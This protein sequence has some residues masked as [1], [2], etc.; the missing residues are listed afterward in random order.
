MSQIVIERA[1]RVSVYH[2]LLSGYEFIN[3]RNNQQCRASASLQMSSARQTNNTIAP[4]NGQR[5][6]LRVYRREQSE[7][8]KDHW[9]ERLPVKCTLYGNVDCVSDNSASAVA[10][11][12]T[13]WTRRQNRLFHSLIEHFLVVIFNKLIV[14]C[15]IMISPSRCS[16]GQSHAAFRTNANKK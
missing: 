8:E 3:E 14:F 2:C 9:K 16:G 13:R 12:C 4:R 15:I 10:V 11:D 6:V 1:V 5:A 7:R